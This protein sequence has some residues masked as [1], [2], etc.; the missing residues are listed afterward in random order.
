MLDISPSRSITSIALSFLGSFRAA[1]HAAHARTRDAV[2]SSK[3]D[4]DDVWARHS[5]LRSSYRTLQIGR[6]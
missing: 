6:L 3:K 2:I 4:L 1:E 5:T